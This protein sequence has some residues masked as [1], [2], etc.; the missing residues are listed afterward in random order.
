M[1][2]LSWKDLFILCRPRSQNPGKFFGGLVGN[3]LNKCLIFFEA[4]KNE[5][6]NSSTF[7]LQGLTLR[8]LASSRISRPSTRCYPG[9]S[10]PTT[11]FPCRLT[12]P[13]IP[14]FFPFVFSFSPPFSALS[15]LLFSDIARCTPWAFTRCCSF[16]ELFKWSLTG[17]L[18]CVCF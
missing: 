11:P 2:N 4:S 13:F 12:I 7:Y 9:P 15:P 3:F 18:F 10:D 17:L 16:T 14:F 8:C 5:I 1:A 6:R